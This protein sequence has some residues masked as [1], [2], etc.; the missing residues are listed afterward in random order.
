[1][2]TKATK[3]LKSLQSS[4]QSLVLGDPLDALTDHQKVEDNVKTLR[5]HVNGLSLQPLIRPWMRAKT[6]GPCDEMLGSM[7]SNF[8]LTYDT[9]TENGKEEEE[10]EGG[11]EETPG[12][13]SGDDDESDSSV[14]SLL[15]EIGLLSGDMRP[16]ERG[17]GSAEGRGAPAD[18]VIY[19]Q[20]TQNSRTDADLA[21]LDDTVGPETS[22]QFSIGQDLNWVSSINPSQSVGP[23]GQRMMHTLR[24]RTPS[25][26]SDVSGSTTS[27]VDN[28]QPLSH[29]LPS[30][31]IPAR[32]HLIGQRR[33][34]EMGTDD[35]D[36]EQRSLDLSSS[37]DGRM[38]DPMEIQR[39]WDFLN[40][41]VRV[42][43]PGIGEEAGNGLKEEEDD[44]VTSMYAI[45]H[46]SLSLCTYFLSMFFFILF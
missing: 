21:T 1:M 32:L 33:M 3:D 40:D 31:S 36:L 11:G 35:S 34:L 30:Y 9:D 46:P 39:R 28:V 4:C 26:L 13:Q 14:D 44:C 22:H 25:Q 29:D 37:G 5:S 16:E 2:L 41:R 17:R 45:H 8:K 24:N 10:K 20:E 15:D 38:V 7:V 12:N 23:F 27:D 18:K 19:S 43:N 6:D 42:R